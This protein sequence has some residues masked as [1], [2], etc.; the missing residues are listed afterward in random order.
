MVHPLGAAL[1]KHALGVA[2]DA[3]LVPRAHGLEQFDTRNARSPRAVQHDAA[4]LDLLARDMQRI[5]QAGGTDHGGAMLVVV[6]NRNIA[7]FLEV[8]LDDE[9]FRRLDILE[10]DAAKGGRHQLDRAAELIRVFGI[11]LDID[12]IHVGEAF[13][14]NRLTLHHG[15]GGKRTKIAKPQYRRPVR[16]DGDQIALG[17]VIIGRLG[18]LGDH[19]T[20]HGH[21]GR[22]CKAEIALCRHRGRGVDVDLSRIWFQVIGQSLFAGDPALVGHFSSLPRSGFRFSHCNGPRQQRAFAASIP[23]GACVG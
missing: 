6:E 22:I 7:F 15:F 3:V 16:D 23:R 20:G 13:E 17:G 10:V 21:A 5:D 2:N 18:P 14:Q 8:L 4:I 9:T 11:Q 19:L 1:I 12:G